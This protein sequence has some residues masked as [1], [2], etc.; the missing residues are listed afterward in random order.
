MK[1][2]TSE[3]YIFCNQMAMI[4]NSGFSL[5]QGITMIYEEI[6]NSNIKEV[7]KGISTNLDDQLNFSEALDLSQAFDDYMVNL[8]KIG[9]TSGNLDDVMKSL[10]EY[11]A[12]IDDITNKLK[13]ALTYPIILVFMMVVV[14]GIIVFKVLP[15]F[16]DVLKGLGTNLSTYAN[17][18]MEFGQVFSLICF[19]VLLIV[20]V[21]I[22]VGFIYQKATNT[23]VLS[24]F[25]Q[26]SFFTK[27]LSSSLSKA[28]ITYALSLFISSG[29]DLEEAMKFV[30]K[31]V[32]DKILRS[33]LEKCSV[34]LANGESFVDVIKKYHIYQG[35]QLNMI[36]VGFKTGQV[37]TIMKQLSNS[38]QDEFSNAIDRFLNIIEPTIV[39]L[40]SLIVGVVLISVMLPLISIMSSL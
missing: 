6:D 11:Y 20:I 34:E 23:N 12:R 31:L 22:I 17:T 36:Q 3:K 29:Y 21:I 8:V 13:Q 7:L 14:V 28:Q 10:G 9:E 37:D 18:F 30:P 33:N 19:V 24:G 5:N 1:L 15:I 2:T 38:F 4:L 16:K 39:A 26:K 35:I 25:I 32:D 40:L 27:K